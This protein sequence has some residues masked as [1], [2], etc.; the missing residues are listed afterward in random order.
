MLLVAV[1]IKGDVSMGA[2]RWLNLGFVRFQPSELMK[3]AVPLACA[4]YL[5]DRPLPPVELPSVKVSK[6]EYWDAIIGGMIGVTHDP[7]GTARR[8]QVGAPYAMAGKSGTAQ[9]FSVG[10][11]EKY[12]DK[13]LAERLKDHA[14]FIAFAPAEDPKIA[15]AVMVENG[16]SGSGTAGPIARKVIDAYLMPDSATTGAAPAQPATAEPAGG[17]DE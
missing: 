11:N 8:I 12:S 14:L 10:Q 15:V 13:G 4:W 17:S 1:A 5:H 7:A 9:V 6:P 3:L 16:K 2:Q